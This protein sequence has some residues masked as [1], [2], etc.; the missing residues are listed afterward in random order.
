MHVFANRKTGEKGRI[1]HEGF[2]TL[3]EKDNLEKWQG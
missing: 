3:W 2:Y 1:W